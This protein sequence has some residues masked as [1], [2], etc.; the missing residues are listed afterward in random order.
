M[1]ATAG[2]QGTIPLGVDALVNSPPV[3]TLGLTMGISLANGAVATWCKAS[4]AQ[5]ALARGGLPF[6][7]FAANVSATAGSGP[8]P[9]LTPLPMRG[10]LEREKEE[11]TTG[12]AES[13]HVSDLTALSHPSRRLPGL[14]THSIMIKQN[15]PD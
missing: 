11:S 3:W 10:R 14:V 6:L 8:K 2:T 4:E 9:R 12:F 7:A 5:K 1:G 13:A 15:R